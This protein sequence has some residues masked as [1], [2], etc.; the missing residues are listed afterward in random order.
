M[1]Q[2]ILIGLLSLSCW[3]QS[4][5]PT[6]I[7]APDPFAALKQFLSLTNDQY[8]K[9][10]GVTAQYNRLTFQKQERI[11]DV[12]LEIDQET[13]KPNLDA[14]ALGV[15]YL[16]LEVICRELRAAAASIPA[17]SLAILTDAQK[18]KLK[19]L[20]DALK[21]N[22][23]ISQAQGLGLLPGGSV[24]S[25]SYAS[26]LVGQVSPSINFLTTAVGCRTNQ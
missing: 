1:K 4:A 8:S 17:S 10:L 13:A 9:L 18:A 11:S 21:L 3:G 20:E 25:T 6:P 5:P 26:F 14:M 23:A 16:E 2:T 7:D 12:N 22:P 24:R 19:Q 15:R